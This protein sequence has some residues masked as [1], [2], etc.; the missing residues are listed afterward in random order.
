MEA[1]PPSIASRAAYETGG[2][3]ATRAHVEHTGTPR[4]V[5][6]AASQCVGSK[7]EKLQR[8]S[9]RRRSVAFGKL[10]TALAL[11]VLAGMK[12]ESD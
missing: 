5:G 3:G 2:P 9:A 12:G 10:W 1:R 8:Q 6:F 11:I 7:A 4:R